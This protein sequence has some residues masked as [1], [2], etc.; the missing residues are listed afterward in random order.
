MNPTQ[1]I[2]ADMLINKIVNQGLSNQLTNNTAVVEQT[3]SELFRPSPSTTPFLPL[4]PYSTV[5]SNSSS[6]QQGQTSQSSSNLTCFYEQ[7]IWNFRMDIS[8]KKLILVAAMYT[9]HKILQKRRKKCYIRTEWV[10]KWKTDRNLFGHMPLLLEHS[11]TF[12][13]LLAMIT[14]KIIKQDT[15]MR[16][17]IPP[18]ERLTA[19]LRFLATGRSLQDLKFTTGIGVSTLCNLIPETCQAIYESL[20]AEYMKVSH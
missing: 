15:I 12:N 6:A 11:Q 2:Y 1:A 4:S 5:S 9:Y 16:Q 19:T 3:S 17:S 8:N 13:K 10:K 14:R 7:A 20:K 18:E